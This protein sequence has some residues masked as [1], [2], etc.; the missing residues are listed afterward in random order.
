MSYIQILEVAKRRFSKNVCSTDHNEVME[1]ML[2]SQ[3]Y[4]LHKSNQSYEKDLQVI[5]FKSADCF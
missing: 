1:D 2:I 5:V 3:R 4:S